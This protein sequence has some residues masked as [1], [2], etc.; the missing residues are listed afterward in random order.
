[1]SRRPKLTAR[2]LLASN[3]RM[4]VRHPVLVIAAW[5]V[6]AGSLFAALP[7]L[8][9]VA[10]RNP[11][12]FLP[13]QSP[14]LATSQQMKDAFNEAGAT[15]LIAVIL[16]NEDGLTDADEATYRELVDNLRA[17]NDIVVSM[18][19]FVSIK[20]IRPAMT[21]K[22]GKAWNLP[23]SLN[24]TMGTGTGQA[25]YRDAVKI[26]EETTA[27]T[28]LRPSVVG[29]AAT[30]EDVTGIALRD[31]VIIEVSTVVTV[32]LILIIVYRNLVAMVIPL[33]TIGISLAVAQQVVAGLGLLGLGLAPQTI[34]LITGM[35]LGAGVDYAVFFFSRYQECLREGLKTDD[36][37][38]KSMVTIGEVIAGSAGTVALTFLGLS[39][40]TLSVF[41]TVGPA[42]AATIFIGFLGSITL[43][44]AFITLAGRRGWVNPRKDITGPMWRR[45]GVSIV[46]RPKRNLFG[47]LVILVAL[48]GCALLVDFN[49]DDRKNLPRD[50][51][52]NQSYETMNAHFPASASV[53]QFIV[54]HSETQDL[55]SPRALADMEQMAQRISQLPDIAAVRGITRPNGEMLTEAR[56]TH[57]AGEVGGKL[58]E[59]T[60]LIDENDS[61]L[62]QLSEG[63]HALAAALDKIRDQVVG[64]ADSMRT[65]LKS[66]VEIEQEYGGEE[67]LKDINVGAALVT[68]MR[69]LGKT[70]GVGLEQVV[71]NYTWMAPMVALLKSS[72]MCTLDPAC[73]AVRIDMERIV[74]AYDDG[75]IQQLYELAKQMETTQEGDGLQRSVTG[76]TDNLEQALGAAGRLGLDSP[77]AVESQMDELLTG[78]NMLADSSEALAQGVQLLVDQTRQMGGGLS[79]ASDF[80]LA[81]KR[82]A[83]D[84]SMSG[85]YIPP[86]ILTR[87][88]FEKA[89]K[90]FIS[91]DGH[92]ARYMVQ[93]ALDPFGADAMDQVDDIVEAALSSRPNTT[94]ADADIAM[95]GTSVF[96]NEIRG[97]YNGDIQYIVLVTLIVVFLILA[98]L[99][100]AIIAP[101]Y[102]V[103]SVVLSYMSAL[104]IAVVF[105][106]IILDQPIF[107]NTPGMTFLVLVAVGAD[108]NL[109]LISRIREEA[110][111][112]TQVAVIR[113]I[114]ATGGVI[115][116]AGLIFA[117]SML[118]MTV[119]SIAAI[120]QLGF[121]IGVGL[122][123]D[124]FLV[125]T[126]TVPAIA[127]M[128]GEKNWWPT[129]VPS[130]LKR[131]IPL[132]KRRSEP[133]ARTAPLTF[134]VDDDPYD[135]DTDVGYGV[136]VAKASMVSAAWRAR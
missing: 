56:A 86:Q 81:M 136:A 69:T 40:A 44:P 132:L 29:G 73:N 5:L 105:F 9:T 80:L 118:A 111:R 49:Y 28:T 12:G 119:S 70:M 124:T 128:L 27:G 39:F 97:Y 31:Q 102:L 90:L 115:T 93:T 20:E 36:A 46:R 109:L 16:V 6:I 24:G 65:I 52:S 77:E 45:M 72:P 96:Q 94:L 133:A 37:I 4:I 92:T 134:P 120:V 3:G 15:N 88:E 50:S 47:S 108:Y 7:P 11:P 85:F 116:S 126:I 135:D 35:M 106:Q 58:G 34:V 112:G 30:M 63:A 122:L 87:P 22:D 129:T 113:T 127:V 89:A 130:E 99:L 19:D 26:I 57:Q 41:S 68:T 100:K 91:P 114:G 62:T 66:L 38:M 83:A 33:L 53:Q 103:L 48:A 67:T 104:G 84:P 17:R 25:A 121:I 74:I 78:V 71:L 21:S 13:E 10:Q 75:T 54:V 79:Q 131:R 2:G 117:A 107:W 95:V 42:L 1:M 98:L 18:Q 32:L 82:D 101:I 59:A 123:L 110:H 64:S 43:L 61:R 51:E 76:V 60:D 23:V 14:V 55:R 8:L 125:R